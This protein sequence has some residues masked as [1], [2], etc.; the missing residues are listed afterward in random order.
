MPN[1]PNLVQASLIDAESIIF[2]F[3]ILSKEYILKKDYLQ[4]KKCYCFLKSLRRAFL[5][6]T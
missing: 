4:A 1:F 2:H 3:R 6:K 5:I